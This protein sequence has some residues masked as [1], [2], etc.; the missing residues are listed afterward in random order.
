VGPYDK[1]CETIAEIQT[2]MLLTILR[3]K[4]LI[5]KFIVLILDGLSP[6]N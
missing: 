1:E 2:F 6:K 3:Q 4:G 5:M